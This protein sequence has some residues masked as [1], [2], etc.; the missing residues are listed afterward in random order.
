ML[1]F[2]SLRPA[3]QAYA[4]CVFV[5][6]L[7]VC[8][9]STAWA[10]QPR[11]SGEDPVSKDGKVGDA[12]MEVRFTDNSVLKM[13]L[14]EERIE[15]ITEYGK[16]Y[17]P[18]A[19]VRRIELGRR[20]PEEVAKKVN[21]ALAELG[22]NNY[23]RREAA[24]ATLLAFR[25][26]AFPAVEKATKNTDMEVANRAE[27]LLK[28]FRDTVPAELLQVRDYDV[29]HT[30]T[31]RIAGHIEAT[32]FK[33]NTAQFGEVALR[34][35]DVFTMSGR[36]MEAEADSANVVAAPVNLVQYQ[37][38]IGKT[39]TFRVTGNPGGS[40]WGTDVYTTDTTLATAAIHAGLL[41]PGQTASIKVSIVP[42]PQVF[43]GTTRN[44]ITSAGYSQYPAA[45]RMS[46]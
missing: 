42:S 15:F 20:I 25:E 10:D 30:D 26:K 23:R 28:K 5:L 35:A 32:S 40:V 21:T 2:H 36:G 1:R 14:R 34:L 27:E 19:D 18:L 44:G 33:A 9:A 12:Q 16:L 17:I 3:S 13:T 4:V 11:K 24:M 29:L 39:Y 6:G 31:S 22:N 38:E 41:T 46:R 37:N 45:F 7:F 43:I 8:W